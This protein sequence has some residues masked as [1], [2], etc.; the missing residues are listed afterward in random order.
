MIHWLKECV[1]LIADNGTIKARRVEEAMNFVDRKYF[2]K[3]NPHVDSPQGI[4]H[5]VTI[6]APHM[7]CIDIYVRF[8]PNSFNS[9]SFSY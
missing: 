7:V 4:G 5:G 2:C 3:E 8:Q 6:S 9:F 1:M